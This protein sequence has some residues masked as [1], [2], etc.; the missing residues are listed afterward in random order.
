[1][2]VHC[3]LH[4]VSTQVVGSGYRGSPVQCCNDHCS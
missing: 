3:V 2:S 1:M 4:T